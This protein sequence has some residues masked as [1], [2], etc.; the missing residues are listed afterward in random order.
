MAGPTYHKKENFTTEQ[1]YF[2]GQGMWGSGEPML[3]EASGAF[4]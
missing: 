3:L 2:V 4:S 1:A